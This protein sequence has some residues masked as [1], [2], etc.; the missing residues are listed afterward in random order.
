MITLAA[1]DTL[2]AG[3]SVATQLT[4]TVFGMELSAGVEVYKA[5][6]Q[7]QLANAPET[8][9]TTPPATTTFGKTIT[10]VNNDSVART[11][12]YFRGGTTASN[13]ITG[14][15]S[16]PPLGW[17]VWEDGEGWSVYDATGKLQNVS[18]TT[19]GAVPV[20]GIIMWSGTIAT[21]PAA[22][23]LCDG[24]ANAPGPDLRDKFVVGAKQDEAGVAKSNILGSLSQSGGATGHSHSG[25]GNLS[26]AGGAVG[27]H[28]GL[29]HGL[30]V[31][32][33]PDLTHA[34]LSHAAQT[35]SH[36]DHSIASQTHA[37]GSFTL[38]IGDHA[39]R[40]DL[41]F[42][43]HS[44]ASDLAS[45]PSLNFASGVDI[46]LP[47]Y[48]GSDDSATFTI[49]S[50][51]GVASFATSTNRS[52]LVSFVSKTGSIP[53]VT[54]THAA[55]SGS[56]PAISFASGVDVSV[57]GQSQASGANAS[58]PALSHAAM[59][60]PSVSGTG[61]SQALAHADHSFPSLSHQAVGTHAA[62]DYGVH[63]FTAP[64]AHGSAG[65]VTHSF[66]QPSDHSLSAHDTV[67][68]VPSFFALAFIQRVA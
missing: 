3:A 59:T 5:L 36:A 21:I 57:D 68:M 64:P 9:Y 11:A 32:N 6:D 33:H 16:I 40:A 63:S 67:S 18:I 27:D 14:P 4:S 39:S 19:V 53:S 8:I 60:V 17:A 45:R 31:A 52:G 48:T 42:P 12:Q 41:S 50:Q 28:T 51:A 43:S 29:T 55:A 61:A 38:G 10:V 26:H 2:A 56:R 34:A 24:I 46:S 44:H 66:T 62:T 30:S 7:R 25:H 58:M 20:G 65:T 47:S 49:A 22:W 54:H 1:G 23:A 13:A 37:H 35:F 15:V